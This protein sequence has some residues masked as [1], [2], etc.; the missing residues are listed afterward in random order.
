MML[1][2]CVG[3]GTSVVLSSSTPHI[4]QPAWLAIFA[5]TLVGILVAAQGE[6]RPRVQLGAYALAVVL[7]WCLLLTSAQPGALAVLL[8]VIAAFGTTILRF[9]HVVAVVVLNTGV[10]AF[11]WREIGEEPADVAFSIGFHVSIHLAAVLCMMAILREQRMRRELTEAHVELQ[12]TGVLL[13]DSARTAERLRISRD[14]HD[15]LGHQLTVLTLEL[16]AA[17]H[18]EGAQAHEHVERATHVA[19]DL[20]ADVRSTVDTLR[21]E[22]SGALAR[23]LRRVG[24]GVPGLDVAVQV[25]EDVRTD[26]EQSAVLLRATQEIV[27]NS[28]R[29]AEARELWIDV[30]QDSESV[31]LTAADDGRGSRDF[32]PGNGLTGLAERFEALGGRVDCDGDQGFR[33]TARVPV[34]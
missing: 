10:I 14:L 12:T 13:E 20:L 8:V 23:S 1:A 4:P 2:V 24:Q 19:R 3:L 11:A 29:H 17:R 16:E 18:R 31:H 7:G 27:T 26:E 33:V 15:L 22:S 32:V 30:T 28:L 6:A 5:V 9:R 21:A 34:R 25:G